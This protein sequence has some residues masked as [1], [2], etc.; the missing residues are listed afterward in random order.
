RYILYPFFYYF[1]TKVPLFVIIVVF[2][3]FRVQRFGFK[4]RKK[5]EGRRKKEEGRGRSFVVYLC[6]KRYNYDV[7]DLHIDHKY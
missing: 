6:E 4:E 2:M 7:F 3:F 5:K 1:F